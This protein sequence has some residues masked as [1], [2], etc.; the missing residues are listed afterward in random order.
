M[1]YAFTLICKYMFVKQ[2][3][4]YVYVK[5]VNLMVFCLNQ[6]NNKKMKKNLI[7]ISLNIFK[8]PIYSKTFPN[9]RAVQQEV[10]HVCISVNSDL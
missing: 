5:E 10:V 7:Y 2:F 3:N 4:K 1:R 9:L 6:F 8:T